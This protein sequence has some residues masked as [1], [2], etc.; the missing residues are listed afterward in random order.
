[1]EAGGE[2]VA[3]PK[4]RPLPLPA[5]GVVDAPGP[6][7]KRDLNAAD[8]SGPAREW[9]W[10]HKSELLTNVVYTQSESEN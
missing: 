2:R 3:D 9:G 8:Q 1:M 7:K 10:S 6:I 4:A 5:R